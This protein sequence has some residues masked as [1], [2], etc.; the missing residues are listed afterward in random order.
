M[1]EAYLGLGSNLGDKEKHLSDAVMLLEERAGTVLALSSLYKSKPW[2]FES[3]NE[4]LN[5]ALALDTSLTPSQLLQLTQQTERDLG[6]IK[7]NN[8]AYQDR[9]ID[10]DILIYGNTILHTP[11]LTLPHP[12]MHLRSFVI[13]PLA[14][15]AP[16]LIHPVLGKTMREL[17]S[18]G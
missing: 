1:P 18:P 12:L 14:E 6:R 7:E 16:Q 15:I 4:F 5:L 9:I 10:I 11:T 13:L 8:G 3:E 17:Q 2:G